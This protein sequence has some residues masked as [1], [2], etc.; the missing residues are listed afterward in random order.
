[1]I[2]EVLIESAIYVAIMQQSQPT[3]TKGNAHRSPIRSQST[4]V[5]AGGSAGRQSGQTSIS[6]T[7]LRADLRSTNTMRT[8]VVSTR[9]KWIW[10]SYWNRIQIEAAKED[11]KPGQPATIPGER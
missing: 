3:S 7:P 5:M 1:M 6:E 2:G 4:E 10:L 9:S 8:L 11:S